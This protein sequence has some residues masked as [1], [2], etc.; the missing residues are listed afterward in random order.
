[1]RAR[2]PPAERKAERRERADDAVRAAFTNALEAAAWDITKLRVAAVDPSNTSAGACFH[3]GVRSWSTQ[4]PPGHVARW[5]VDS[6]AHGAHLYVFEEP[7]GLKRQEAERTGDDEDRE[8][9]ATPEA[10]VRLGR[11]AGFVEGF[12]EG[13]RH[14]LS[15]VF[16]APASPPIWR[17]YPTSWRKEAGLNRKRAGDRTARQETAEACWHYARAATGRELTGR[18]AAR[19]IDEAMAVCMV[20]VARVIAQRFVLL[21]LHARRTA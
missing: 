5:L 13:V 1:M 21:R 2:R 7:F 12:L 8:L 16:D 15:S 6:G 4:G 3:D 17:P 18:E 20:E 9:G 14:K 19:R 10:L 11:S